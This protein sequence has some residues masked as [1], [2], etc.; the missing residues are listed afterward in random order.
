M[1]VLERPNYT[2]ESAYRQKTPGSARLAS[3][4]SQLFPSGVT[5]D[6]R[7]LKPYGIYVERASKAHKWDVDG[8]RYIDY[9]GGH[10]ALFL[11]HNHPAVLAATQEALACGTHFA[12]GHAHEVRWGELVCQ[13]VPSAERLRFMSSGT[14]ASMMGV[15]MA[16]AFSGKTKIL[17]F[18]THFHGWH[19]HLSAGWVNHFDGSAPAGVLDPIAAASVMVDPNDIDGVR[20][21]LTTDPDIAAVVLEPT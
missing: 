16:R 18:R 6:G 4:A 20:E 10:G 8:N 21:I 14:E 19:D 12:T 9:Y 17:R 3:T 15:R 5:H 1:D 7:H 11:G 2:I 13:L